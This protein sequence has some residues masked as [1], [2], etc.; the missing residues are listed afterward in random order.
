[1][2]VGS[3]ASNAYGRPR[4]S[5]DADIVIDVPPHR[6]DDFLTAFQDD[7]PLEPEAVRRSLQAGEMFNLIPSSGLFKVDMIPRRA[8][9]FARE[10]FDRRRPVQALGRTIWMPSPEDVILSKLVWYRN[11]GEVSERQIEDARDVYAVQS[12]GLDEDYLTR[13]AADLGVREL[14]ERIRGAV[15]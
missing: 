2:L 1:M 9:R 4:G 3:Y 12:G 6:I 8:S 11:G 10:E 13:S 7:F 5:Y 14:L 15:K